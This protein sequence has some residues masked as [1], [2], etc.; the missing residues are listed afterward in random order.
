MGQFKRKDLYAL[1]NATMAQLTGQDYFQVID[2]AT[3]MD[4]GRL[5]KEFK[6][7]E[8]YNALGIVG[9]RLLIGNRPYGAALSL[10]DAI[11]TDEFNSTVR[12]I[13]YFSTWALPSGAFNTNLYTN[14]ADGFD[15]GKNPSSANPPV[16]QSTGDQYEQHP[17]HPFEQYFMDSQVWQD[18]LTRYINQIKIVFDT[19]EEWGRFWAGLVTEK[20]NDIE[21]RKEAYNRLVLLSRMGLAGAIGD[22]ASN[23]KGACTIYDLTEKFNAY[24]GTNYTGTQ[25][26]TTYRKEFLEW[27]VSEIKILSDLMA[28]RSVYFHATPVLT[29]GDGDHVILRHTPK[30][31]QRMMM[32]GPFWTKAKTMVMPEIFNDQYLKVENFESVD[33]WQNISMN[34]SDKAGVN[35]KVTIPAWLEDLIANTTGSSDTAYVFNPD[36]VLGCIFDRRSVMTNFQLEAARTTPVEAR[37]NYLN[38]WFDYVKSNICNPTQNFVLFVMSENEQATETFTGDG[39]T[40]TFTLTGNVSRIKSVTVGGTATTAYTYN[41]ETQV[42]TFSSAPANAAAIKVT[43]IVDQHPST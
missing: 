15:N 30:S 10:I 2:T 8:I 32:Y 6:T 5:A 4:A 22:Y 39:S 1:M 17:V 34:D 42:I 31:E 11:S 14:F 25:L 9:A 29:L 19:E 12:E 28:K 16:A 18:C 41:A 20:N 33:Y 3:F 40:T 27:F 24:M 23:L 13:S 43:Y 26:R 37:K 35:I 38:T 21:Q 36:Y 7:D